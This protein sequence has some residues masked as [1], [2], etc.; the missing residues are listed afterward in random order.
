MIYLDGAYRQHRP[1]DAARFT[2]LAVDA[3]PAFIGRIECFGADWLGRQFALDHRRLIDGVPQVLT[4]EPG[5]GEALE[6]PVNQ[7]GFRLTVAEYDERMEAEWKASGG[8]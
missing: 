5:T 4:L 7:T 6:I 3:F 8:E 1:E 2:Q